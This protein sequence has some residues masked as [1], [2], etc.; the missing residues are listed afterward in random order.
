MVRPFNKSLYRPGQG[1]AGIILHT[2]NVSTDLI[3]KLYAP[4]SILN[5]IGKVNNKSRV[6][7]ES[8]SS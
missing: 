5:F 8:A 6:P 7:I 1:S 3:G 2:L 4:P